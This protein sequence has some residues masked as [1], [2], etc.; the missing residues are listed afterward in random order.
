MLE[1]GCGKGE[2]LVRMCQFGNNKGIGID[3]GIIPDRTPDETPLDDLLPPESSESE[4]AALTT[5][6]RSARWLGLR[7]ER[8]ASNRGS[9]GRALWATCECLKPH[10][11]TLDDGPMCVCIDILRKN[12]DAGQC[13]GVRRR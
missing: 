10:N 8:E 5:R 4:P 3:P 1:I 13:A 6:A 11:V 7:S 12:R 9:A 2:F